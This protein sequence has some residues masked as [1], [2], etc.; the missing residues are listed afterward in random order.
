MEYFFSPKSVAVI[1]ATPNRVK[2]G[3]SILRNLITSFKGKIYPV[4]PKYEIMEGLPCYPAVNEI[5]GDVDT[6]I[7]FVP[8]REVPQAVSDC[9][10]KNIPGVIIESAGFSEIGE[11]G[12]ELQRKL[13]KIRQETGIRLW[14][15]NCMGLV[16]G[17]KGHVFSF[18]VPEAI[19]DGFIPG[20]LSLIV[21]SGMLSGGFLMDIVS[22]R[23]T[24]INKVCSVGNKIDIDECDLLEY[25][26]NDEQTKVIGLYLES[27]V[28]GRRFVELCRNITKPIVVLKGGKSKSGAE[29][30][31]S[32]TAS[33]AG[34]HKIIEG[35]L[36]QAGVIEAR[37]FKQMVDICRCLSVYP[38]RPAGLGR[39]AILTAS[40]GAGI[41]ATDFIEQ[42]KL[43]LAD[44]DS[45]TKKSLEK[46]FPNW[47]PVKNPVDIWPAIEASLGKGLDVYQHSLD[48]LLADKGVDAILLCGFAGN[49]K[50]II[51]MAEISKKSLDSGKPIFIWLFG[52]RDA[53]FEAQTQA[54]KNDVLIF[55]EL[56][57]AV[58]CLAAV[59]HQKKKD[60]VAP[61]IQES[62]SR[63]IL[64]ADLL[65][66]IDSAHG[67]LDE[68]ISKKILQAFGI[69]VVEEK[70]AKT[71]EECVLAAGKICYPLV[72]KGIEPG[73]V[74]KTEKGLVRLNITDETNA[75]N[76]FT[77]LMSS[78]N[79]KGFVLLQKQIEGKAEI[80]LGML[81][82]PHFG[83][84]VM[85]G[86]GGIMAEIFEQS[87]F[88]VAPLS[89]NDAF[90]LI[91]RFPAKNLLEGFRGGPAIDKN[92][93]A[94][95]LMA[96]GEI[97]L[98]HPRIKEI[99]INPLIVSCAGLVAVDATIILE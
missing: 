63:H 1:G 67:P 37:D 85:M 64:S 97:G 31:I 81:K 70:T 55:Q 82:D 95:F 91:D 68:Y 96:L 98:L 11:E 42:Y 14:G 33:L 56:E 34:N 72:M 7:I 78:M 89:K 6:A 61:V 54:Q 13:L 43:C 58:E 92:K 80:I 3:N 32:H 73:A 74:H 15:P 53:A 65:A 24:G 23:I 84:A 38:Q 21:Q 41:V 94:E 51:E 93:F 29:A 22:N 52:L 5:P 46:V 35:A 59:M 76:N 49:S 40:G 83:P 12:H 47:M 99:D 45:A 9:A 30:A 75:K 8:A 39:V 19:K 44:F 77:S 86:I 88:A 87:V 25:F 62:P 48:S 71:I 27:I 60:E 79:Q 57:R 18:M 26:Q 90:G 36:S 10:A 69:T 4:N 28:N 20:H 66:A 16:D 2:G 17:V 50:V